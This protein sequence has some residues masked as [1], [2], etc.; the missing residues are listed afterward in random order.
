MRWHVGDEK[1]CTTNEVY[2][3]II[4]ISPWAMLITP[5]S[6]KVMAR[7][8]AHRMSNAAQAQAVERCRRN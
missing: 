4:I 2:A 8:S 7:P 5:I 3:P 6:P 1:F